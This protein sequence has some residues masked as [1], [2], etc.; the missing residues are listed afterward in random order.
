[1]N[2]KVKTRK[3]DLHRLRLGFRGFFRCLGLVFRNRKTHYVITTFG[4]GD[5]VM[6]CAYLRAYREAYGIEHITV[7]GKKSKGDVIKLYHKEY[8]DLLLLDDAAVVQLSDAFL[9]DAAYYLFYKWLF[10]MTPAVIMCY[11]KN[12]DMIFWQHSFFRRMSMYDLYK[13]MIYM[14]PESASTVYPDI[15]RLP[16]VSHV[17][18]KTGAARG[19]SVLI[20]PAANSVCGIEEGFWNDMVIQLKAKGLACFSNVVNE[21][22]KPLPNTTGVSLSVTETAAFAGHCGYVL[23]L[24][25][26]MCDIIQYIDCKMAVLFSH[27]DGEGRRFFYS[28]A[29]EPGA[30]DISEFVVP[31]RDYKE[32][33]SDILLFFEKGDTP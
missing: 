29:K 25:S 18:V 7:V 2:L 17:I 16:D 28:M 15:S 33:I 22:D 20:L 21:K 24:R 4:I 6:A 8:D 11:I 30:A 32:T 19:R 23:S 27:D 12:F 9:F 14:L 1:M 10:R 3:Q 13:G 31:W 26:G 5:A